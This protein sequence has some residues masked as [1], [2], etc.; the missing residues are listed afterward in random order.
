MFCTGTGI[1]NFEATPYC[2]V[3]HDNIYT[4]V[5]RKRLSA[6]HPQLDVPGYM[7]ADVGAAYSGDS[8]LVPT[9]E[10]QTK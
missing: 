10:D 7:G 2:G 5:S 9:A 6:E 3:A 8:Y 4:A 1:L